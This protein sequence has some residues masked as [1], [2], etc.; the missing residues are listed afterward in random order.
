MLNLDQ[1][2]SYY[3]ES[4]WKFSKGILR[5]YLQYKILNLGLTGIFR[6]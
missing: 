6:E 4:L 5:E 3:P 1:I 2:Q